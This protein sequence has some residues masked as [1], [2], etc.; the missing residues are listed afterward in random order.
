MITVLLA[1]IAAA[2]VL[3]VVVVGMTHDQLKRVANA[4]EEA[5]RLTFN[6]SKMDAEPFMRCN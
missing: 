3:L 2:A 6:N 1:I 5:N 4:A